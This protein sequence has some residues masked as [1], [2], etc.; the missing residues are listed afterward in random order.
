MPNDTAEQTSGFLVLRNLHLSRFRARKSS[1]PL[2]RKSCI[3]DSDCS[4]PEELDVCGP[5]LLCCRKGTL[6]SVTCSR[7]DVS[8]QRPQSETP[9]PVAWYW[10]HNLP[11]R[12][13][14]PSLWFKSQTNMTFK[15]GGHP[16][17][18]HSNPTTF[19]QRGGT[20]NVTANSMHAN[21][22]RSL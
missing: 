21:P 6:T 12:N 11:T 14:I 19:F 13:N 4:R 20:V 8:S 5:W 18:A 15:G 2:T 9:H 17:L 10:N 22:V 1:A 16:N 7:E 3:L